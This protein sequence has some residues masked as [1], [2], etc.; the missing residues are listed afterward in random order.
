MKVFLLVGLGLFF[1]IGVIIF[2][3]ALQASDYEAGNSTGVDNQYT[4]QT[5]SIAKINYA[6]WG[7]IAMLLLILSIATVFW[8]FAK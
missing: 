2:S 3:S 6:W 7:G 1:V 5:T 4:N 8:K